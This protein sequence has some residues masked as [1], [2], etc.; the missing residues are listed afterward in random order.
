MLV[1]GLHLMLLAVCVLV[2]SQLGKAPAQVTLTRNKPP[3]KNIQK[4][5]FFFKLSN[6]IIILLNYREQIFIC[7]IDFSLI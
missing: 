1:N 6:F 2:H 3:K 4:Y 7:K 5:A